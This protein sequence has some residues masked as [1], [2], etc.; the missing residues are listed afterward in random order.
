M[1]EIGW[2]TND[3]GWWKNEIGWWTNDIGWWKNDIG[4]WMND[5]GWWTNDIG[6]W[7]NEIGWW[8]NDIGWWKNDIGGAVRFA[9]I[10]SRQFEPISLLE[11]FQ[12]GT[13]VSRVLWRLVRCARRVQANVVLTTSYGFIVVANVLEERV[14]SRRGRN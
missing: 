2:W 3:I 9:P 12:S 4:W 6:W 7:K 5:I 14:F 11:M 1:N 13:V 8:T 10:A